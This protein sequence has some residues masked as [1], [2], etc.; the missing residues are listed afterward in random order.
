[1]YIKIVWWFI[2]SG[3]HFLVLWVHHFFHPLQIVKDMQEMKS[4]HMKIIKQ[5]E[6]IKKEKQV[7][8]L[9]HEYHCL[10]VLVEVIQMES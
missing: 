10:I 6:N 5:L 8:I 7:I 9:E 1:M 3:A 2:T 4:K